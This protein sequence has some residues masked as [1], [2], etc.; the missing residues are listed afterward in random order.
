MAML[1]TFLIVMLPVCFADSLS[2]TYD[3]NGNLVTG[4]GVYRVYNSLNQLWKVY[5]NTDTTTILQ[6]YV[7]HPTEE[8]VLIKKQFNADGSNKDTTYYVSKEL[9]RIVNSSGSYDITYIYH[10]GQLI[11]ERD[12]DGNK[13]YY[14]PDHLGSTS[15]VTDSSGVAIEN[16]SYTPYGEILS[17]GDASRYQYEGKEFDSTTNQY[18]FH[19]RGYKSEWGKFT[20]PDSLLPNVYDPQQLNRYAFESN[21][22]WK[23][24][25]ESGHVHPILI[26]LAI[27][28]LAA[29]V[30]F[31]KGFV[32]SVAT[33]PKGNINWGKA[34]REGGHQALV[35]S[36]GGTISV[37]SV[38]L[39]V[40]TR[41]KTP[42]LSP[43]ESI[44]WSESVDVLIQESKGDEEKEEE[45]T[46][47]LGKVK[48]DLENIGENNLI[49][50]AP[51]SK[52]GSEG[53][54]TGGGGSTTGGSK[55]FTK[56]YKDLGCIT[57]CS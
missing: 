36:M 40:A 18:D 11:A 44:E 31:I 1:M 4:D 25:D 8:R 41:G 16:S 38:V 43:T 15:L 10:E 2:L 22:P 28:T 27:I 12:N 6:E 39:T 57:V 14:M 52:K 35:W 47:I 48:K 5:N 56:C 54:T 30:G 34:T 50:N 3:D 32:S 46:I 55:C 49:Q 26:G 20:Q 51:K 7:Y 13:R 17:G 29:T 24:T 19:F 53:S 9:V 21:N 42:V 33:Q 37:A 45:G 23:Y